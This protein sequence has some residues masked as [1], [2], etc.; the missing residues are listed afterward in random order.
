MNADAA[1]LPLIARL[2]P[3]RRGLA[4]VWESSAGWSVLRVLLILVHGLVP[5]AS[6]YLLKL[7][8]ESITAAMASPDPTQ[9]L[10]R[11]LLFVGLSALAS[12]IGAGARLAGVFVTEAQGATVTDYVTDM[13]QAKSVEVDLQF[14]EDAHYHDTLHRAQEQAPYRPMH[15]VQGLALVGHSTVTLVALGGLLL[16][17]EWWI[18][19]ALLLAVVPTAFVRARFS[20]FAYDWQRRQTPWQRQ[21]RYLNAVIT[22]DTYAKEVRLFNL[23]PMLRERFRQINRRVRHERTALAGRRSAWEFAAFFVATIVIFACFA[24]IT[25]RAVNG[26]I[27]IGDVVMYFGA[28][29]RAQESFRDLVMGVTGLY[30]DNLFLTDL[31]EFFELRQQVR[32]PDTPRPLPRPFRQGIAFENV[33]FRY[34]GSTCDVLEN[35]TFA[36]APG[37]HVALVGENGSGKTTLMKLLCRLYDP[38]RGAIRIDG[39]DIREFAT[40]DLRREIAVVFQDFARYQLTVEENIWIGNVETALDRARIEAAARATG[41]DSVINRLQQGYETQLGKQFANGAE[42]SIGEWQKIAL[43]RA[44]LRESQILVMDEPTSALDPWAEFQVYQH[45]HKL[46][47]GQTAI[48][49]SHRLSAMRMIDRIFVLENG[50]IVESGGHDE[51]LARAGT[52]ARMFDI[53]ARHYR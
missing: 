41:A 29:Q 3:L 22:G 15:I 31:S 46:A 2:R 34:P 53:Q 1:S 39:V 25:S 16:A 7:I 37:E 50:R 23:G 47:E 45:F 14:Y 28:F 4:L 20:Q 26:S 24:F 11:A 17:F 40:A 49:I 8:I 13:L 21:A 36:I 12:L 44:F 48:L 30:E 43:T 10:G 5:L 9:H 19:A 38:T 32:E 52:Y 6:L 35:I 18:G 27:S 33:S 51:L 42:L